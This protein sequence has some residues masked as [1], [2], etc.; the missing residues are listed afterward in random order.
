MYTTKRRIYIML[1]K[2]K[3]EEVVKNGL[4]KSW[5][6]KKVNLVIYF[7]RI[8]AIRHSNLI[9]TSQVHILI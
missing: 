2:K 7:L 9:V 3:Y 8:D 1:T 4:T 6:S 5:W